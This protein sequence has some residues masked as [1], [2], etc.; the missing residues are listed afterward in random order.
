MAATAGM[1]ALT[2]RSFRNKRPQWSEAVPNRGLRNGTIVA[3]VE[4][5]DVEGGDDPYGSWCHSIGAIG[6]RVERTLQVVPESPSTVWKHLAI[7]SNSIYAHLELIARKRDSGF[8]ERRSAIG[9]SPRGPIMTAK[10]DGRRRSIGTKLDEVCAGSIADDVK[11]SRERRGEVKADAQN[12]AQNEARKKW[13]NQE[14]S[15]RYSASK[16]LA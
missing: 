7:D 8:E 3:A 10:G 2:L 16:W 4:T 9:T 6:P 11:P 5:V 14:A 13:G 1:R 12:P 15:P